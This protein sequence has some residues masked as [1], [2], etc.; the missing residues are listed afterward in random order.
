MARKLIFFLLLVWVLPGCEDSPAQ[1]QILANIAE[2]QEGIEARKSSAVLEHMSDYFTANKQM[3]RQ[4]SKRM[5]MGYFLR[6]QSIKL[7]VSSV[8]VVI[9]PDD[10]RRASMLCNVATVGGNSLLPESAKIYRVSGNWQMEGD[11][12]KL[13]SLDW[14]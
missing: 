3:D 5:L 13:M 12:W 7:V 10:P 8:E 2:M 9:N 11:E 1:E 14:R 4:S 6:Y